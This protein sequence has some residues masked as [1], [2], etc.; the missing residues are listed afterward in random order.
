MRIDWLLA[1]RFLREGRAQTLFMLGGV[2]MGVGVIVFLIS[3]ITGLQRSI[4]AKTLGTQAHVVM[5]PPDDEARRIIK[6]SS[7][8]AVSANI[9]R[10][11]QRLSSILQWQQVI[12]LLES[13]KEVTAV[14]PLVSGPSFAVRGNATKSVALM[15]VEPE[16]YTAIVPMSSFMKEGAFRITANDA[17]IGI[18]LARDLGASLGDKIRLQTADG[19][20]ET[21]TVAG[22][23]DVGIRDLNR[24]WV[25]ITLR[26]AQNLLDLV[27]GVSSIDVAIRDLFAAE[28]LS[29]RLAALTGLT[30]ESWMKT[31]AQ[32]MVGL[33]SQNASSYLIQ[34]F[35]IVSVAFGIAS[36]L[37]V[38]VIQ[39][40]REIGI[41][42][43]MGCSRQRILRV[44]LL[45][46]GIVG[47]AGSLLGCGV[48]AAL[49]TFFARTAINPD[50]T[51]VFPVVLELHM[52]LLAAG[53]ATITG[54]LAAAAPAVRASKL[55]PVVAIRNV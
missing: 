43:A 51:Q 14:S 22:I 24:R 41:L 16:R 13:R 40:S 29:G 4:I 44:F 9:E 38:S 49:V 20:S 53:V 55:D 50:G 21:I 6:P 5:R 10:R 45:Q 1:L 25:F 46:G 23:F 11:A 28:V 3:L 12:R 34:F 30:A 35:V 47:L 2:V 31:N 18:D 39:K 33:R 7:T 26:S 15:G 54:I 52:F 48:G 19:R 17:A 8:L 32:L 27:G 36:V 42:R 37:V